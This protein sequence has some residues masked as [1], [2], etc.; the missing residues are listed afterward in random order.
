MDQGPPSS[1]A[2]LLAAAPNLT[3]LGLIWG[4]HA[5]WGD[6][7]EEDLSVYADTL[8]SVAPQLRCLSM[9]Y[10]PSPTVHTTIATLLQRCTSLIVFRMD[11]TSLVVAECCI[12]LLRCQIKV[13]ELGGISI[14]LGNSAL[15]FAELDA[16][17]RLPAMRGLARLRHDWKPCREV[18]EQLRELCE[19]RGVE[20][21]DLQRRFT[22]KSRFAGAFHS[23]NCAC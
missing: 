5:I 21:R 2:G 1:L 22:G 23:L 13:L 20:L 6:A 11:I 4:T 7:A 14:Q 12:A 19:A 17:L 9:S 15:P 18:E 10:T 8:C 3:R 16:M